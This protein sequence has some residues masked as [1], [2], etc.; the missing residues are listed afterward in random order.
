M[1][2]PTLNEAEILRQTL[3][4]LLD[5]PDEII[6]VD[7]GSKDHTVKVACEYTPH[8]L[9]SR[10][11]RGLQQ[12]TGARQAQGNV[13]VFVHADTQLP[14]AY[15]QLIRQALSDPGVVLGAFYLSIYPGS[16][17]LDFIAFIAN[18]RSRLFRLP[19]GD[20]GLFVR[21][22]AY[23][24]EGGFQDWP[25]MEDV[26]LVRRLNRLGGFKLAHGRVRT[27][28]RRWKKEKLICTTLRNWSLMLR[29]FLRASPHT[30]A[31]HYPDVR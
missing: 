27:S 24:Q 10:P 30:L 3:E 28:G 1:I 11:G 14:R 25:I 4:G 9:I 12:H 8:V 26:D 20:Q 7:G 21:R 17:G 18:L 19:Y 6:V 5:Q 22:A 29:Y 13:L 23:F 16:P 31:R 2:I 15:P